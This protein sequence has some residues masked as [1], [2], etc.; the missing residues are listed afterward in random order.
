MILS[1][2]DGLRG[3]FLRAGSRQPLRFVRWYDDQTH[4]WEAFRVNPDMAKARGINLQSILYRG[5]CRLEFI[6]A[7][8]AGTQGRVAPSTPLDEI[9][10]EVLKGGELKVKPIVWVPGTRPPECEERFCHR[11]AEWSVAVERIV[12][13]ERGPEGTLFERAVVVACAAWCSRHYRNPRQISERGVE[14]EIEVGAR[15]Q[16]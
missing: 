14:S 9:R 6:P 10:A 1:A 8:A 7:V 11:P 4:E 16:W 12:E 5:R 15:P 13:P 3:T 2:K